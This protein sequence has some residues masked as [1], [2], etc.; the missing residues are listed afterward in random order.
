MGITTHRHCLALVAVKGKRDL[1][2]VNVR[3]ALK[4]NADGK[5]ALEILRKGLHLVVGVLWGAIQ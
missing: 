1:D 4:V 5:L 2:A 3:L